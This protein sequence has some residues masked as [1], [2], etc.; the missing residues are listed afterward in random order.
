MMHSKHRNQNAA[1]GM[2]R[3]N[4]SILRRRSRR[5]TKKLQR[6]PKKQRRAYRL[7]YS[8]KS[9]GSIYFMRLF[10][11]PEK[12]KLNLRREEKHFFNFIS[13]LISKN[14]PLF[15]ITE[16]KGPI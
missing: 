5:E 14:M 10:L 15:T 1:S 4:A 8:L 11:S 13:F 6:D 12:R 9:F 3:N 16:E 2:E 7:V